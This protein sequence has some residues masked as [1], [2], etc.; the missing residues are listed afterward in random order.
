MSNTL[1]IATVTSTLQ[2]LLQTTVNAELAGATVSP[3]RPDAF[4]ATVTP[5]R[6]IS[7]YLY[8]VTPNPHWRNA[9][10]TTRRSDG[11]TAQQPQVALDLHYLLTFF[12]EET[13]LEPQR[14]LGAVVSALHARPTLTRERIRTVVTGTAVLAGSDLAEQVDLVRLTP[15]PLNL[16]ELSR[17]WS[18]FF[19]IPYA[20][21]ILYQASVVLIEGKERPMTALPVLTRAVIPVPISLPRIDQIVPQIVEFSATARITLIGQNLAGRARTVRFGD[22]ESGPDNPVTD[23]ALGVPL[24]VGLRAGVRTAQV[25][26]FLEY[27]TPPVAHKAFESNVAPFI[28]QPLLQV[29]TFAGPSTITVQVAPPIGPRQKVTLLLNEQPPLAG[30]VPRAFS[31][32]SAGRP[33]PATSLSFAVAGATPGTYLVRVQV[34]GAES[35]LGPTVVIV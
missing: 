5:P 32:V 4:R 2:D 35:N 20:L 1:A 3:V 29:V 22:L 14:M 31:F 28:L 15:H 8:Q 9:D 33:V 7:L 18:V 19:Q 12:G 30:T 24:P 34:D 11:S 6:G 21:S 17:L 25:V 23:T 13:Q 16:E 10:L 27:S 26:Q